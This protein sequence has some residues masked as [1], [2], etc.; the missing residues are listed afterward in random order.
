[1][2]LFVTDKG[3]VRVIPM[4]KKIE[5]P[6]DFKMFAKD[7]GAPDAIICDATYEQIS[8]EVR[9]FCYKIGTFIRVLEEGT[10]WDNRAELYIGL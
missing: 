10:P 6:M 1:M 3:F 9:D 7:I 5:V 8:K 4:T 2:Q